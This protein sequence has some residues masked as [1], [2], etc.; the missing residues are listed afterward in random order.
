MVEK[1]PDLSPPKGLE[2]EQQDQET[3]LEQ[4]EEL[5]EQSETTS[6]DEQAAEQEPLDLESQLAEAEAKA[7]EYLDGWQRSRAEFAN[8][9]RRQD[10][11]QKTMRQQAVSSLLER[12]IA[13]LDDQERAY[14]AIPKELQNDAWVEGLMLADKKLRAVLEKEGL[15][16]MQA[17]PGDDFD[18]YYHQA[19]LH[20]PSTEF[21]EGKIVD[22]LQKGYQLQD[23][24]LRPAVVRVSSGKVD[25]TE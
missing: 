14:K 13:A 16:E 5:Q 1:S 20:E 7:A 6:K 15:S 24:V 23:M 2:M 11:M 17:S 18:P 22:V 4:Q 10:Q 8:F 3:V 21:D 12:L 9:R 19:I 25:N